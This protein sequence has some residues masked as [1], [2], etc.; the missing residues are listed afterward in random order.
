M[1]DIKGEQKETK[2]LCERGTGI[3]PA[4]SSLARK[5]S[6][7]ELPPRYVKYTKKPFFTQAKAL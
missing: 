4:T 7:A 5:R 2:Q 1:Q 6:I 3:K